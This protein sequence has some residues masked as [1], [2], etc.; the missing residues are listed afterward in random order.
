MM[1]K[2]E[3][4]LAQV[5]LYLGAI[6]S[7]AEAYRDNARLQQD[8]F[9]FGT[10]YNSLWDAL[11][12]RIGT[13][14]DDSSGVASL[15]KLAKQL[16]RLSH[17]EAKSVA[18]EI[19]AAPSAE[20]IRLKEWRHAIVAHARFPLD[21][22]SFDSS[23]GT[24]V[25]DARTEAVRIEHMLAKANKCIGRTQVFYGVLKDDAITNA[26][27]SLAGWQWDAA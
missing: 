13:I 1:E 20:W 9:L 17:A 15:P 5:I 6:D 8:E 19:R 23:F 18:K 2:L 25:E 27:S 4:Q 21:L 26:R 16:S 14:W 10:V 24:N 22:A 7:L 11:V 3:N 12:V